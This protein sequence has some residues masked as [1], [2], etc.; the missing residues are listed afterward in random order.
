MEDLSE[1]PLHIRETQI[2]TFAGLF[3]EVETYPTVNVDL[4]TTGDAQPFFI[5][6][7]IAQV[8]RVSENG[9]LYDLPLVEAIAQQLAGSGG[10]RGHIPDGEES[11]AFPIDAVDWVGHVL[12]NG[13]LWA[14]AYVPPGETREYIRRLKARNGKLGT[15]IYG[16]G[17]RET[18]EG[19]V[20]RIQ[21][22]ELHSVDLAP[23]KMASLKLGGEYRI[24]AE[25]THIESDTSEVSMD[26]TLEQVPETVRTQIIEQARLQANVERVQELV[27]Q[28]ADL[29]G[30]ITTLTERH[31]EQQT[32]ITEQTS[33]IAELEQIVSERD[34]RIAT[35][36]QQAFEQTLVERIAEAT[37]WQVG[38]AQVS[39]LHTLRRRLRQDV[40]AELGAERDTARIETALQTVFNENQPLIEMTRDS[41]AGP[42]V[43][44]GT[45]NHSPAEG[46]WE[47]Y[48]ENPGSLTEQWGT[49]IK[50]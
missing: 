25:T 29:Q 48:R 49:S 22:F 26:I 15:S 28:V 32:H 17:E 40:L 30:Q 36:E 42:S 45:D 20:W 50:K 34:E 38:E 7:P 33:R 4:L 46:S 44:M 12:E 16:Y 21:D 6:L 5:T 9:L 27:Q 35:F 23:A 39:V 24:T 43:H 41:L 47:S 13:I 18:V 31:T 10:I 19:D 11:T 3:P 37:N 2:H 14:K 8:G 1:M